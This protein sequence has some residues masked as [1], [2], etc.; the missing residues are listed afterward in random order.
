M[1]KI[2]CPI[3]GHIENNDFDLQGKWLVYCQ[4]C[5]HDFTIYVLSNST[6]NSTT[7][8]C[9]R[10]SVSEFIPL[11]ADRVSVTCNDCGYNFEANLGIEKD[12]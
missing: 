2:K 8:T 5:N 11:I 10:C 7:V 1:T 3:C 12:G 6:L 9:P 4:E